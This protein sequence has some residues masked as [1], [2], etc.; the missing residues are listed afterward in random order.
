VEIVMTE[1]STDERDEGSVIDGDAEASVLQWLAEAAE[2]EGL[3]YEWAGPESPLVI[4]Y[5]GFRI[6]LSD[7]TPTGVVLANV[8]VGDLPEPRETESLRQVLDRAREIWLAF[9]MTLSVL[10]DGRIILSGVLEPD[11]EEEEP[12]FADRLESMAALAADLR[13]DLLMDLF[14]A[15]PPVDGVERPAAGAPEAWVKG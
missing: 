2:R 6:A 5:G 14:M 7:Q 8:V 12:G 11:W 13:M 9:G 3:A 4:P 15:S 10:R 1:R